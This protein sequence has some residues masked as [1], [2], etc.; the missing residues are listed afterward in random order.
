MGVEMPPRA[1]IVRAR[2][3]KRP[4]WTPEMTP[5]PTPKIVQMIAAPTASES[6]RGM[7]RSI[8]GSTSVWS[9]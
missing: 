8:V 9:W 6:V 7:P 4:C 1:R 2:S 3:A 5:I